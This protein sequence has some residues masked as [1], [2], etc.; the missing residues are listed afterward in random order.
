MGDRLQARRPLASQARL[1]R[2]GAV[3]GRGYNRGAS[4]TKANARKRKE[5]R[6]LLVSFGGI[7]PARTKYSVLRAIHAAFR[8]TTA[9]GALRQ[10]YIY[11]IVITPDNTTSLFQPYP[12][13]S[14]ALLTTP[15]ILGRRAHGRVAGSRAA[16]RRWR[17]HASGEPVGMLSAPG[18]SEGPRSDRGQ[19]V[20]RGEKGQGPSQEPP[21]LLL[22]APP[23]S[24]EPVGQAFRE[25]LPYPSGASTLA[26]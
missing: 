12:Q 24:S 20:R 16:T 1:A 21:R 10:Y 17:P 14:L 6:F 9:R 4:Y 22:A 5:I 11:N 23:A 7:S 19:A 8:K 15:A 25:P 26:V 3:P 13:C 18:G 2:N